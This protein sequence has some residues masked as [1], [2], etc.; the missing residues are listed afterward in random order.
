[1]AYL[2]GY[3][4]NP[5]LYNPLAIT[6]DNM[7]VTGKLLPPAIGAASILLVVA[8]CQF[9]MHLN[10]TSKLRRVK[11]SG[12]QTGR[13]T[14]SQLSALDRIAVEYVRDLLGI[15]SEMA[16]N[17]WRNLRPQ[18]TKTLEQA[19]KNAHVDLNAIIKTAIAEVVGDAYRI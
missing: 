1:M 10:T 3:L 14:Q 12:Y 5:T 11:S 17:V 7:H 13:L 4:K 2:R 9:I 6:L 15:K 16:K 8:L 19:E 18:V